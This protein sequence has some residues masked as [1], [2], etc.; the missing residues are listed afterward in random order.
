MSWGSSWIDKDCVKWLSNDR[1]ACNASSSY[2]E[3]SYCRDR[4]TSLFC[5]MHA[6]DFIGIVLGVF[7]ES[8]D[9]QLIGQLFA[10]SHPAWGPRDMTCLPH[11]DDMWNA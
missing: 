5:R 10:A 11:L 1:L 8:D 4:S 2:A 7:D 6:R 9:F 3:H